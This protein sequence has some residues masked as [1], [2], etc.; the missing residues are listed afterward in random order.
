MP[1]ADIP[2][3]LCKWVLGSS[4]SRKR[5]QE[6][7]VKDCR[8]HERLVLSEG[9]AE[10]RDRNRNQE[11]SKPQI[12]ANMQKAGDRQELECA[13]NEKQGCKWK[14]LATQKRGLTGKNMRS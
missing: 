11:N 6:A 13:G 8:T 14:E 3:L 10:G 2:K 1:P 12:H 9:E 4:Q 5:K 7:W